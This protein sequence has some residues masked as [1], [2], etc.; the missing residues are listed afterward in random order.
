[1]AFSRASLLLAY[2]E[3]IAS[4]K[5]GASADAGASGRG[6]RKST[7]G[8]D[9]GSAPVPA[10]ATGPTGKRD[11]EILDS[12]AAPESNVEAPEEEGDDEQDE[13]EEEEDEEPEG[14]EQGK[15]IIVV[16]SPSAQFETTE[17]SAMQEDH[18][19]NGD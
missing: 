1:L 15:W 3:G 8:S 13:Q 12:S 10:P 7:L 4:K 9:S 18:M 17:D 14:A 19:G 2:R 11:T 5:S 6:R 16:S